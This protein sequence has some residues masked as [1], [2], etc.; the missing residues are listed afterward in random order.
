MLEPL[1]MQPF[2]TKN[3]ANA[4]MPSPEEITQHEHAASFIMELRRRGV[5][6]HVEKHSGAAGEHV[7]VVVDQNHLLADPATDTGQ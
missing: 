5:P 6:C 2:N 1:A 4:P 7:D 3:C